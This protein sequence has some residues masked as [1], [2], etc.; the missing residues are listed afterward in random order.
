MSHRIVALCSFVVVLA[1]IGCAAL[2]ATLAAAV[3]CSGPELAAAQE[4]QEAV[5]SGGDGWAIAR[6][7]LGHASAAFCI[8][9]EVKAHLAAAHGCQDGPDG[10]ADAGPD[11]ACL[12]AEGERQRAELVLRMAQRVVHVP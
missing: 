9:R 7:V 3:Q 5:H 12:L 1:L 11:G 4:T 2:H 8:A 10:G 6:A